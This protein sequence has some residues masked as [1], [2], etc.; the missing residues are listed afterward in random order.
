MAEETT[1]PEARLAA[2]YGARQ[3][4][5]PPAWNSTLDLL[6]RHRSHRLWLEEE[7][8]EPTLRTILAAAQS[9][10]TSSNQQ[11]VS[12]V[13]VRDQRR[14]EA[15]AEVGGSRQAPHIRTAPLVLVWLIDY[16]HARLLAE[17]DGAE[18]DGQDYLDAVLVAATDIGI[19][20]QNAVTAAESLG[21]GT[22]FLGS[23]RNDVEKVAEILELPD[24]VVP[25]VGLEIGWPDPS[26]PAGIK[27]RLPQEAVLH[28]EVYGSGKGGPGAAGSGVTGAGVTEE[29]IAE[30]D[31]RL[32]EYYAGFG[33]KHRWSTQL[34]RRLASSALTATNRQHI[35][36][37]VE[38]AGFR[39]R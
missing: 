22:V 29:V 38:R 34:L 25:F 3:D 30:Y 26:E 15:L 4:W 9:G 1:T 12:V 2:R 35:R 7:V 28:H 39:M 27:P 20:G 11:V 5:S 31:R 6:L 36:R 33:Q 16:S 10:S 18:I 37:A 14:K 8:D 23:L 21:L 32:A 17:R 24:G 13:A 19:A